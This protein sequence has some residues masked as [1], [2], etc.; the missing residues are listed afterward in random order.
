MRKRKHMRKRKE[1]QEW[2]FKPRRIK[3][4]A[5]NSGVSVFDGVVPTGSAGRG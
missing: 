2:I 3:D 1:Q 5:G 4:Q